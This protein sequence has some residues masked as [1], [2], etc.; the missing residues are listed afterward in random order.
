[1]KQLSGCPTRDAPA[2]AWYEKDLDEFDDVGNES[3]KEDRIVNG[4]DEEDKENSDGM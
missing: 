1:M 2:L 4:E 3:D